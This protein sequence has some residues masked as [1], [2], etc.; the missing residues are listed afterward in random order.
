LRRIDDL[1]REVALFVVSLDWYIRLPLKVNFENI[2]Q[3]NA[4]KSRRSLQDELL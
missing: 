2:D 1:T 4:G 3:R